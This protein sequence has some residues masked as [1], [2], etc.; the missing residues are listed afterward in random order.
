MSNR[1]DNR[2]AISALLDA[3]EAPVAIAKTLGVSRSTVYLVKNK[4][5]AGKDPT[6]EGLKGR[7]SP[8]VT[9]R[10]LGGLKKRIR[11][12]PKKS[13]RRVAAEAGMNRESVR[14]VVVNA[15]WKSRRRKR[16][17]LISRLGRKKCME[18]ARRLL[19]SLKSSGYP[20]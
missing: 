4:K 15:G 17:P 10:V 13:L 12:A 11:A 2:A 20:G 1:V 19:N 18:R 14:K 5:K 8:V 7:A 16:V 6:K 3:G 9:P